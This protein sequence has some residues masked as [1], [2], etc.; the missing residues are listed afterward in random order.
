MLGM[1]ILAIAKRTIATPRYTR[2]NSQLLGFR[3]KRFTLKAY[4][5]GWVACRDGV[6]RIHSSR[7]SAQRGDAPTCTVELRGAEVTPDA[8]PS[9]GRYGIKLEVPA[10]DAMHEMWLRC[11]NVSF[12]IH[13]Q[14]IFP[15]SVCWSIFPTGP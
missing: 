5:R 14:G 7:E 1:L 4:K 13:C 9:S 8:H 15:P 3:P 11:E 2:L 6:L 10:E 12:F